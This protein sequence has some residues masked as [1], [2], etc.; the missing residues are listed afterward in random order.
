MVKLTIIGN[1]TADARMGEHNERTVTSFTVAS[2]TGFKGGDGNHITNFVEVSAWGK[3]AEA[4]TRLK[5]GNKVCVVGNAAVKPYTTA[6]GRSGFNIVVMP[7]S[8]EFLTLPPR[9]EDI[10]A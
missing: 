7:D 1:L 3:L 10:F 2:K 6:D 4:C 8:V 5:K 9:N